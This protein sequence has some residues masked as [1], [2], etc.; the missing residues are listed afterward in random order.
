MKPVDARVKRA[1]NRA[2]RKM[3]R[4]S[5]NT[6][7]NPAASSLIHP[8]DV[9]P[10][11][12]SVLRVYAYRHLTESGEQKGGGIGVQD[13]PTPRKATVAPLIAGPHNKPSVAVLCI[14]AF[15][16]VRREACTRGEWSSSKPAH[17]ALQ[18]ERSENKCVPMW[19]RSAYENR[20]LYTTR[21]IQ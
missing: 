20:M 9:P 14:A 10:G 8:P 3:I 18:Q 4:C 1:P 19:V 6:S 15:A 17:T 12:G 2:T 5:T 11:S 16:A 7:R 13:V 21:E